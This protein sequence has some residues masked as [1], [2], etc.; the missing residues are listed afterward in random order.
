MSLVDI[1]S[2]RQRLDELFEKAKGLDPEVQSHWSRYLCVLISGFLENSV[3]FTYAEYA[4]YRSHAHVLNFIESNLKGFQ[5]PRMNL[6]LDMAGSFS[7]DW[8][9]DLKAKTDGQLSDSVTSIVVNRHSI[10][11]GRSVQLSMSVLRQYYD[12]VRKVI[13]LMRQQCGLPY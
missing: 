6:I 12:D 11:H 5:N 2:Q 8:R 9:N 4:S 7:S 3:R 1:T 13:E 10:V